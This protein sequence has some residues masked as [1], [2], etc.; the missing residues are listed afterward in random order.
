M[1]VSLEE[2][3]SE[4]VRPGDSLHV[5]LGHCRWTAAARELVRQRW[6]SGPGFTLV[7]L[8]LGSLGA[9]FFRGG[10]V[11]KV[12]TAYSGDSFP[13]Y[14]PNPVFQQAY[15]SGAVEVE[16]W[17][18]LTFTQRLEAAARGLPA[19]TTGSLA[20]SDMAAN[21]DYAEVGSPFGNL[22]LLAPLT[23]DVSLL[24]APVADQEGNVAL[25]GPLM[26]GAWGA[27]AARRGCVVTVEKVVDDLSPW[28]H[29][30]RVPAHR[31]LAVAEAPFGAHPGGLFAPGLP[32]ESYGEDIPFW[33]EARN[34]T[35][36]DFDGWARRWVLDVPGQEQYLD[37]LGAERLAHLRERSDPGSWREDEAAHPV[38]L[39][40]PPTRLETAAALGAR[41]LRA[42]I[43]AVG[44]DAVL[45]GAGV[46]NL[47]AWVAVAAERSVGRQVSLTA[48]LGLWGYTPTPADPY[49]FNHRVFP[50]T[51]MLTDCTTVLGMIVGGPGTSTIGCLGAAQVDRH[52][53]VNST[54]VPGRQ[55]LVGSGGANDVASRA[56]ECVVVTVAAPHR[57]VDRVGY[58]TSPGRHVTVVATDKGVLRMRDGELRLSAVPMSEVALEDRVRAARDCC[59]WDLEVDREIEEV[60]A[61]SVSEAVALRRYDPEGL[62]LRD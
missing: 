7:M 59:G 52:G 40:S 12:V 38:D 45:A 15:A 23:P 37:A 49:I 16:H 27:W 10:L 21:P 43:E 26:E 46:A 41:E 60:D 57:L 8:S 48:E 24:H 17:S 55:F 62:F 5:F 1:P 20:G 51:P 22:G 30:V 36:G 25:S 61:V 2:A 6:G 18:I 19:V 13:T 50:R 9:L 34:A 28:G 31:V 32:V 54:V 33:I 53:N 58:V 29:L 11:R 47:S 3:V 35:R 14:T 39:E 42:R 44:A 56:S 4:H